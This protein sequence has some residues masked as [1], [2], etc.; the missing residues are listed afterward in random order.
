MFDSILLF[1]VLGAGTGALYALASV[2]LV[3]TYRGSGVINF[4]SGAMGMVG[5]FAFYELADIFGWPTL[6]AMVVAV[7]VSAALGLLCHLLMSRMHMASNLTKIVVTL[8]LLVALQGLMGLKYD[9]D[10]TYNVNSF[11]T[12][13]TIDVAGS[14]ISVA[15]LI[16]LGIAIAITAIVSVVYRRTLFGLATSAVSENRRALTTLG[17]SANNVSAWNWALGAGLAG[18]AGVLLSPFIGVSVGLATALL[19]PSLAASVI[20]NF[21]SFS[22]ALIGAVVIGVIQSELTRFVT[23]SGIEDAVPFAVIL[24]MIVWRGR[25]V[26]LRGAIAERL[27]SV[28]KGI[29]NW[30]KLAIAVVVVVVALNV[31]PL[32]W[33]SAVTTTMIAAI[34]VASL[35]VVTGFAGQISLAQWSIGGTAALV[36]GWLIVWGLPFW[37]AGLIG[38]LSAIPVGLIIGSAALRARGISLALATLAFA[39]CIVSLLLSNPAYTGNGNG[40]HVGKFSLFGLNLSAGTAPVRFGIFVLIV[41]V[42]VG[43]AIANTRRGPS[44]RQMLAVRNNERAA[45]A[46]GLNVVTI[47][48]GAFCYGAVVAALAG[49]VTIVEY[50]VAQYTN[51]DV[52]T[53]IELVNYSVLGGVGYV[54]GSVVGAQGQSGGIFTQ[55][56]SYFSSNAQTYVTVIFGFL[57]LTI[58]IQAPNGIARMHA[59]KREQRQAKHRARKGL[60]EPAPKAITLPDTGEAAPTTAQ[61][62]VGEVALDVEGLA[63]SYGS[64]RAVA[65]V[66]FSLRSGEVLGVIG[67]NGAGKTTLIDA[68]TGFAP[69]TAGTIRLDGR[70]IT[71]LSARQRAN[72]GVGRSFQSLEVFEDLSVYE[73]ILAG[74]EARGLL[75]WL[76]DLVR[77]RAPR[78]SQAA[79]AIVRQLD[80][81]ASLTK[82]PSELSYGSRRL[83]MI[84]RSVAPGPRVLLLDEPAAGL[85]AREREDLLR[86]VRHLAEEWKMA[87]LLIEH[88][89]NWVA[90]AS[91]RMLALDFGSVI[92]RGTPDEVRAHPAVVASYLGVDHS[93]EEHGSQE[94]GSREHGSQEPVLATGRST[95]D[96]ASH[97]QERDIS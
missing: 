13:S 42:V 70:D 16:L 86:I 49:I 95:R 92:A 3:L 19:L 75:G 9:P 64:V 14:R 74:C 38:L 82:M 80:L 21:H 90:S 78:L 63:V 83:A 47:K 56:F 96:T 57:A 73:N 52:F 72:L 94:H 12:T 2:G 62:T 66:D 32:Q 65:G 10:N 48:L 17:W 97:N 28:T 51:F 84:A 29:V 5:T 87:V 31:L 54:T 25:K 67:A 11:L 4:A 43:L 68:L 93:P 26:P 45:S 69:I 15:R 55:I 88:D 40:L 18:L 20:G 81:E 37:L 22:L 89:V 61:T 79:V 6:P 76:V 71:P 27:P 24:V 41:L 39:V 50:P 53:N 23:I 1:A 44:G 34:V 59:L 58:F 7:A 33:V 36:T 30:R 60:P 8:A 85:D 77:P 91:D 35:V 46:L